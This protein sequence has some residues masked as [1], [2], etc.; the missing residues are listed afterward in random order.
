[1]R[2]HLSPH[3]HIKNISTYGMAPTQHL[4]D[5]G[6]GPQTSKKA[7]LSHQNEV[8]QKIKFKK[9]DKGFQDGDLNPLPPREGVMK[10]GKFLHTQKPRQG[11]G[12]G[13]ALESQ[14]G[15]QQQG[16]GRQN[17]EISPQRSL[18][19][20]VAQLRSGLCACK[21]EWRLGAEALGIRPQGKDQC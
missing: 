10:G 15:T 7:S 17:G 9:R 4:L 13:G 18:L 16:L 11:W 14:G 3:K 21:S 1:M 8:R 19:N 5:A 20:T 2:D 6:R 12:Q